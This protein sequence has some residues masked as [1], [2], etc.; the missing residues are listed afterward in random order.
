MNNIQNPK[1]VFRLQDAPDTIV[2]LSAISN[3]TSEIYIDGKTKN[4]E[5]L[6][7]FKE[8]EKLWVYNINQKQFLQII[9]SINP[10]ML[11][12]RN[13][14]VGDLSLL[15]SLTRL[16]ILYVDW[17]TKATELW[18]MSKNTE[19]KSLYLKDFSALQ[20]YTSLKKASCL[21][22]LEISGGE[23]K[24]LKIENLKFL[25]PLTSLKYL[26]LSNLKVAD[27]SLEPLIKLENL[28]ILEISNQFNTEEYAMLSIYLPNTKC[29]KFNP[30]VLMVQ[31]IEGKD[32][33]V[34]GK[35]KPFL[36]F[37]KDLHKIR[38]YEEK[39]RELQKKHADKFEG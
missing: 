9:T 38:K 2:D 13:L 16:E 33:M 1:L 31:P 28:K 25:K 32:I 12:I 23:E 5:R 36:S 21:E 19:L 29:D 34:T 39:F 4:L 26:G 35:R 15:D 17:N 14:R 3:R 37:A 10:K 20:D 27:E 18:D 22:F 7:N 24:P 8:L 11:F 30:Y 6:G